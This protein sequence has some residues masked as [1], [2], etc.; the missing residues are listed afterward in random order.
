MLSLYHNLDCPLYIR[1][2]NQISG[3]AEITR[4]NSKQRK[5]TILQNYMEEKWNR[6]ELQSI[7][8]CVCGYCQ[9]YIYVCVCVFESTRT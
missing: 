5:D 9:T 6:L 3:K 8:M 4:I 2:N 1:L 7:F